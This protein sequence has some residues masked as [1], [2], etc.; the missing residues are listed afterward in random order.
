MS[1]IVTGASGKLGRLAVEE[2]LTR[3]P[4]EQIIATTRN[5]DSLSNFAELGVSVRFGDFDDRSSLTE[6]F[7]GGTKMLLIS[8]TNATGLRMDQHGA[9]LDAAAEAGV[10]HLTFTSMPRIDDGTH[11]T[12]LLAQEYL[13]SEALVKASG[14]PW[15]M[16]RNAPYTE[17]HVVERMHEAILSGEIVSNAV[18][19]GVSFVSRRDCAA[20]AA[21][22]LGGDGH[23]SRSYD[24]T[25]PAAVTYDELASTISEVVGRTVV[26]TRA[27]DDQIARSLADAGVPT[28]FADMFVGWGP[29][30]Q[31]G[32]YADVTTV[33]EDL[34]GR[35]PAT[36]REVLEAHR[37]ELLEEA[38]AL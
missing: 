19:G 2:L 25:G 33:V 3:V 27:T 22:V 21:A 32:Y 4:A 1:L 15:T 10:R 30:V 35:P 23:E 9:A 31:Q 16:L 11:P 12:G 17:L 29:A 26:F 36:L 5:P 6:A 8:A 28:M 18:S 20:V 24:V 38:A 14:L 7:A 37:S 34:A 13:D